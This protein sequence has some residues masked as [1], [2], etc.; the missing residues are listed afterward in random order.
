MDPALLGLVVDSIIVIGAERKHQTIE[1][2]L[3]AIRQRFGEVEI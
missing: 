3:T 1:E 2:F